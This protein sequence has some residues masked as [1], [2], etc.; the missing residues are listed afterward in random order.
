MSI[1]VVDLGTSGVRAAVV[2]PDA[3]VEHVHHRP[4]LP[5]TPAPG[6]V[7][8]DASAMATAALEV[9]TRALAEGGPVDAVG[10]ANQRASTIVWDRKSGVPRGARSRLAGP[11]DR[12]HLPRAPGPGLP[13]GPQCLGHQV[14]SHP[15]R[16]RPRSTPGAS[17]RVGLRHRRHL[18]RLDTVG[19]GAPR[20]GRHQRRCDRSRGRRSPRDGTRSCSTSC[21]S[22]RPC[23]PRWSTRAAASDRRPPSTTTRC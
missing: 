21:A 15:R 10:I 20:D 14:G 3:T 5:D 1:L 19:R 12:G 4:V 9:A 7:E 13:G 2:R 16:R 22:P 11:P 8:F 6:L 17:R 18:G 23:C